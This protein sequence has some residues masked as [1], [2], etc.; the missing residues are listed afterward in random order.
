M[1]QPRAAARPAVAVPVSVPAPVGGWN[2][3]DALSDMSPTDAV[4]LVNW[5]PTTTTVNLR[6]GCASFATGL[7]GQ[8][9]T[10]MAYAGAAANKLKAISGGSVYDVTSGGAVGAAEISSLSNSRWQ[11]QN[12]ATT[13]G[14]YLIMV[15]GQDNYRVYDGSAWHKDGDGAPYDITGVASS[16][17]IDAHVFKSRL[18]FVQK[19][20]LKAWYL[21]IS[22]IGG[23]AS[24]LDLSS[25][26]QRGGTLTAM[27]TWSLDAGYGMDDYAVWITSKGE[28]AVYQLSDPA[29]PSGIKLIGLWQI[30]S[31]IGTRC[32]MKFRGDNLIICQ[33]G[34]Y[35][36]SAALQSSRLDPR[37]SITDK[38]QYAVS[39]VISQ[40]SGN[41]GW[42]LL[43]FPKENM[44][45]LNVPLGAGSQQQYVMN[46]ITGAWCN[47]TGWPANCWE[48][49]Q[50]N[51]YFGGNTVVYQAWSGNDDA[52]VNISANAL[53]AFS[54]FGMPGVKKRFTRIRPVL[55][56]N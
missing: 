54:A 22:S 18:W 13:G 36:M 25:V 33:D 14:N 2:S 19:N 49:F 30:G 47:F 17:L 41:F 42:Q 29:S 27:G 26:F 50:D 48:L 1:R 43:Q 38:I 11:F 24:A 37:V 8:V 6:F 34:V 52:G 10:L 28:V 53:Q 16:S 32:F 31:P 39:E 7:P 9:E 15:N 45:I 46:T 44:I 20:T 35:P 21:P 12:F 4:S 5:F 55:L 51:P 3:R 56:S 40:Y 23:A